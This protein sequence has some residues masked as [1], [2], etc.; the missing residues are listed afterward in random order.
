MQNYQ[1][2]VLETSFFWKLRIWNSN[3]PKINP[4]GTPDSVK[5]NWIDEG[6]AAHVRRLKFREETWLSRGF[7]RFICGI[8]K[9]QLLNLKG[10]D[11]KF[12]AWLFP[13]LR[14]LWYN[15][16]WRLKITAVNILSLNVSY[17]SFS[18]IFLPNLWLFNAEVMSCEKGWMKLAQQSS[19]SKIP[20]LV[21]PLST[22]LPTAYRP[23]HALKIWSL[24]FARRKLQYFLFIHPI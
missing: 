6:T 18:F 14:K 1:T 11:N 20:S 9:E 8:A 5:L 19:N 12:H 3:G 16:Q 22:L 2:F 17:L 24:N 10:N 4:C 13:R 7:S 21:T 23:K 15:S